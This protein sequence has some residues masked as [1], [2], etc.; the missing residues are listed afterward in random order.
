MDISIMDQ[1][2]ELA[3]KS[4]LSGGGPFAAA[5]VKDGQVISLEHNSVHLDHD[6]SAHAEINAI[7]RACERLERFDLS[8][9]EIYTSCEPCPMCFGAIYWA[10][11]KAVYYSATRKDAAEAG[12][13]DDFIYD[14]VSLSVTSRRI[15]FIHMP[16]IEGKK[17]FE[18][19]NRNENKVDY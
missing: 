9:C 8:G 6:P 4:A 10:H 12:F 18:L 16:N 14:E 11:L 3:A 15:P 13:A 7:R 5:I 2:L 1:V 17:A 19:W